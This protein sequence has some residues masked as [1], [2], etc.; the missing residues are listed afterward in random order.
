VTEGETTE[1]DKTVI[2][3]LADPMIHLIR[4]SCD[5][6][7]EPADERVAAAR[8][9]RAAS[10]S[11]RQSGGEVLIAIHRQRARHQPRRVRAKAEAQG[12]IAPGQVVG[13]HELFR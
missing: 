10:P 1:V 2:D 8:K 13:D 6:G 7:L 11:A 5:H 3:R 4:N 12:L 9:R